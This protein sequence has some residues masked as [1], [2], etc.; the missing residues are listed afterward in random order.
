MSRSATIRIGNLYNMTSVSKPDPANKLDHEYTKYSLSLY[1]SAPSP[2]IC[3]PISLE[4]SWVA[5]C[6]SGWFFHGSRVR[7]WSQNCL[8]SSGFV[9]PNSKLSKA[10]LAS[11]VAS[12]WITSC[13][14]KQL[15]V[16]VASLMPFTW[17]VWAISC[18]TLYQIQSPKLSPKWY[19]M[20]DPRN[21]Q[22]NLDLVRLQFEVEE[23]S[24]PAMQITFSIGLTF[25]KC[26]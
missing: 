15:Q 3:T 20:Q 1:I 21:F 18:I 13:G 6:R 7:T 11:H 10:I 26:T 24:H 8:M 2:C 16:T 9:F 23:V 25:S 12:A 5:S 22:R 19:L 14:N 17:A 4:K